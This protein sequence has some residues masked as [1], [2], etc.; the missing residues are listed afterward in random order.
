MCG[1]STFDERHRDLLFVA[2]FVALFVAHF[3]QAFCS[4]FCFPWSSPPS[5]EVAWY[6][7]C[8][9]A[10]T[11][12]A[13]SGFRLVQLGCHCQQAACRLWG[14]LVSL[15]GISSIG[16]GSPGA[17]WVASGGLSG[18]LGAGD[19]W[20]QLGVTSGV[21]AAAYVLCFLSSKRSFLGSALGPHRATLGSLG[22]SWGHQWACCRQLG[23][24][25]GGRSWVGLGS[26]SFGCGG[27][28]V[29]KIHSGVI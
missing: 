29:S 20:G 13:A 2:H 27:V 14:L 10:S 6:S 25:F 8:L 7:S 11:H 12:L 21:I 23:G 19:S 18:S 1:G 3:C 15:R 9:L 4:T 28:P 16:L 24:H 5:G 17:T 22:V 26:V